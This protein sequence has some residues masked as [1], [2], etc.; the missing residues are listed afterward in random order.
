MVTERM[1]FG[2]MLFRY[3]SGLYTRPGAVARE[4][5][6]VVS[7]GIGNWFPL[8]TRAPAEIIHITLKRT[9]G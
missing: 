9:V 8:R 6:L 3:W 7:N 2:P 1:G 4:E 5:F